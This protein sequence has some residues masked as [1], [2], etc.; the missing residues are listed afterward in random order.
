MKPA[1]LMRV[2]PELAGLIEGLV[3]EGQAINNNQAS[4][5]IYDRYNEFIAYSKTREAKFI[6]IMRENASTFMKLDKEVI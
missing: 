3:K 4:K 1:K 6:A 2:C 5:M